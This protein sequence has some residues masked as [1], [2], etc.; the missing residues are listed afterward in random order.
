MVLPKNELIKGKMALFGHACRNNK[1]NLVKICILGMMLGK[2]RRGRP[3][4][5][6]ID[7]IKKWTR[8]SLEENVRRT[9][10]RSAWRERS[11]AAGGANVRTAAAD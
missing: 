4:M 10:D 2:R 6:Y 8:A 11:Y 9:E 3:R 5:Q 1:R 7:N